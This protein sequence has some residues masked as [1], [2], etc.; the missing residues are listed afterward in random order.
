MSIYGSEYGLY[1][2][3]DKHRDSGSY[4]NLKSTLVFVCSFLHPDDSNNPLVQK[5]SRQEQIR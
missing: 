2:R 4:V 1:N 3:N 5:W